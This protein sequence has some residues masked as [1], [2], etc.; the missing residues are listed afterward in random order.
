MRVLG[1][2]LGARRI[3][4][5]VSDTAGE[6]AFPAGALERTTPARDLEVLLALIQEREVVRVVV[7]L[8][9]HM[10]G[11]V[12]PEAEAARVFASVLA[13]AA[14]LPVDTLDERWTTREAERALRETGLRKHGKRGKKAKGRVDAAA[15]TI[16]LRTYLQQR[17][18]ESLD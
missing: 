16:I 5:A 7:G 11:R 6:M 12:G 3:G 15:A 4:L 10:D 2:D 9:L 14:K 17:A 8:P 18:A 13:D 1:L